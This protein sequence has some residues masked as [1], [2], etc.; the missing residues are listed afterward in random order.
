MSIVTVGAAGQPSPRPPSPGRGRWSTLSLL[1][2]VLLPPLVVGP[3]GVHHLFGGLNEPSL[4][5][6]ALE[7]RQALLEILGAAAADM[8][9]RGLAAHQAQEVGREREPLVGLTRGQFDLCDVRCEL[10]D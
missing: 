9:V 4:A 1:L 6:L 5:G 8:D 2:D 10:P 3:G 7:Q